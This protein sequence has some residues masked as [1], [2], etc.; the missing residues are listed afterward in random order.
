MSVEVVSRN[1]VD[2]VGFQQHGFVVH[3]Q[4]EELEGL[5]EFLFEVRRVRFSA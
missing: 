2:Q 1:V 5:P 4:V 3:I